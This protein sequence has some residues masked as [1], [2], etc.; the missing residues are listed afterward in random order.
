MAHLSI[1]DTWNTINN[2][3]KRLGTATLG[4]FFVWLSA[5]YTGYLY[6]KGLPLA[7]YIFLPSCVWLSIASFLVY[8]IWRLNSMLNDR[9]SLF[10]SI[11]EGPR[12]QWQI[13]FI[14]K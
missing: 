11:E 3:E 5:C 10:P 12:S 13:P 4:V 14:G 7:G 9:Y 6:Y 8:S 1:G 2:V